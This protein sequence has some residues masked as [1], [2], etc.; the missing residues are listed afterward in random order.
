MPIPIDEPCSCTSSIV[1]FQEAHF[2][3]FFR[4]Y[5]IL[6]HGMGIAGRN[7]YTVE[8]GGDGRSARQPFDLFW[9]A[10]YRRA[11]LWLALSVGHVALKRLKESV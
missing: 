5:M 6:M 7:V 4:I 3:F 1:L 2:D 9:L 8:C 10:W 11:A